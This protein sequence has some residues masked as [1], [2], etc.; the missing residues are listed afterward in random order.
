MRRAFT[1]GWRLPASILLMYAYEIPEPEIAHCE[2]P[3]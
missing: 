1:E 3:S 2:S